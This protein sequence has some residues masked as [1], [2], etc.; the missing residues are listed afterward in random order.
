MRLGVGGLEGSCG[1]LTAGDR[2]GI[3]EV[4]KVRWLIGRYRYEGGNKRGKSGGVERVHVGGRETKE[5]GGE[6]ERT[7]RKRGKGV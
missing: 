3:E 2:R 6:R 5:R 7:G 1:A 4:G